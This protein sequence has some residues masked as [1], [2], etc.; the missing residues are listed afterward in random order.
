MLWIHRSFPFLQSLENDSLSLSKDCHSYVGFG[1][2]CQP[3]L[4]IDVAK[5]FLRGVI[6]QANEDNMKLNNGI[7]SLKNCCYNEFLIFWNILFHLPCYKWN[8]VNREYFFLRK[9]REEEKC[10]RK[11]EI[12]EK[13][14]HIKRWRRHCVRNKTYWQ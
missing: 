7:R 14:K 10:K 4:D 12:T 6:Q 13:Q 3:K 5:R 8:D 2:S 9:T 11:R 1:N